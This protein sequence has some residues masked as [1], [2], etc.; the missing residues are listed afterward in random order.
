MPAPGTIAPPMTA[1]LAQHHFG[2]REPAVAAPGAK[3]K[4]ANDC[5]GAARPTPYSTAI[6]RPCGI[7]SLAWHSLTMGQVDKKKCKISFEHTGASGKSGTP[8]GKD[9]GEMAGAD[10]EH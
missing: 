1:H 6:I 5:T 9:G 3:R 2:L 7:R 8:S 4:A 10:Q